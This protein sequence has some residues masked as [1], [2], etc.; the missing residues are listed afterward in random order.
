[1]GRVEALAK[2]PAERHAIVA[3]AAYLLRS[4]G[5][6]ERARAMLVAEIG[7]SAAPSYYQTTLSQWAL[8]DGRREEA[9]RLARD[10]VTSAR[11]RP[12]RIQWMVN[13]LSMYSESGAD[14]G[15]RAYLLERAA[16]VYALL[17]A[18][19]DGFLGRNRARAARLAEILGPLHAEEGVKAIVERYSSRCESLPEG[20]RGTCRAH[21]RVLRGEGAGAAP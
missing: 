17:F 2:T 19:E 18:G 11:G 15:D 13:E 21:F 12:S 5:Q 8:A 3:N 4:I 6:G 14:A 7:K 1:M 10:A 16:E 20:S 9:R